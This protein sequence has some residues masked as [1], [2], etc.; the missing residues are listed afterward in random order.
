MVA[1]RVGL[2]KSKI[3]TAE[4]ES[5]TPLTNSIL[6]LVLVP[7]NYIPYQAGQYLQ[8]LFAQESLSF[9]I[10]NA[11]LG[12]H[13]YELHIR[14]SADSLIN[15]RLLNAIKNQGKVEICLPM[16]NCHLDRLLTTQPIL[17]IA[18]GTGFAPVK[19]M[20]EQLLANDDQRAFELFWGARSQSDLYMDDKLRQWQT[21]VEKFR[22]FSLLSNSSK[23]TLVSRILEHHKNDLQEWQF[24]IAGPL[25]MVYEIRDYL[26]V[27]HQVSAKQLFSDAFHFE[28]ERN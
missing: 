26:V 18:G 4:I 6:Q 24:V 20:I 3:I 25:D 19:A 23:E 14:H 10:A 13:K 28:E 11:P 5:I 1:I 15:Y 8:I 12:A 21:H 7:E 22:Y 27:N 17:F 16:G 2:M 9:S